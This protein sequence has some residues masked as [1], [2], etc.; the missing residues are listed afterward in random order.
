MKNYIFLN[1][2]TKRWN[3]SDTPVRHIN[4]GFSNSHDPTHHKGIHHSN[5]LEDN[6][7][8]SCYEYIINF[9]GKTT[10]SSEHT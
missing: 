7:A 8:H 6:P 2:G 3:P 5:K 9:M 1:N 4:L 10:D